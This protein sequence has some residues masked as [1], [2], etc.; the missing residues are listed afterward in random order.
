MINHQTP[1]AKPLA[2]LPPN[3]K[4]A[5][6]QDHLKP[7][8]GGLPLHGRG[9][10]ELGRAPR[11]G[12][13]LPELDVGGVADNDNLGHVRERHLAVRLEVTRVRKQQETAGV[14]VPPPYQRLR[15]GWPHSETTMTIPRPHAV[16]ALNDDS[17]GSP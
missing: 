6:R 12:R 3:T 14:R 4:H 13:L 11:R 17:V 7:H 1:K 5:V 15:S 16:A 9:D 2:G 8:K 10:D